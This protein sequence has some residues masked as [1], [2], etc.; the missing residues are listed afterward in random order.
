MSSIPS[1]YK[2]KAERAS[3][4]AGYRAG[5]FGREKKTEL[6]H[7]DLQPVYEDGYEAGKADGVKRH[8]TPLKS[9]PEHAEMVETERKVA[10]ELYP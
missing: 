1:K 6:R 9:E 7:K 4:A 2:R 10:R 8:P 3:Y 5:Y